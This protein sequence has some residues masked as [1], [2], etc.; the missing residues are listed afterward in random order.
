MDAQL[1]LNPAPAYYEAIAVTHGY[2]RVHAS[3]TYFAVEVMAGLLS[4]S[5]DDL[6][7][8]CPDP[9][10]MLTQHLYDDDLGHVCQ[11]ACGFRLA[12]WSASAS[13]R[14]FCITPLS[15]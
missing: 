9:D 10:A 14:R 1:T 3:K 6:V 8:I 4:H 7:Q 12:P 11:H 15:A 5:L 2:A 13:A